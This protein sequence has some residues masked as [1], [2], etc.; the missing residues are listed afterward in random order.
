MTQSIQSRGE[1]GHSQRA[2]FP[3]SVRNSRIIKSSIINLLASAYTSNSSKHCSR[4][5][6]LTVVSR[7]LGLQEL[8][9]YLGIKSL[10]WSALAEACKSRDCETGPDLH[11]NLSLITCL[12]HRS[13]KIK[14]T[15]RVCSALFPSALSTNATRI[16]G[17]CCVICLETSPQRQLP[18]EPKVRPF[19]LFTQ[20]PTSEPGHIFR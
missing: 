15:V 2:T 19:L 11:L 5:S 4:R 3:F 6:S 12:T 7:K 1:R 10:R 17:E 8:A 9:E 18:R 16:L 14:H 13:F 20:H